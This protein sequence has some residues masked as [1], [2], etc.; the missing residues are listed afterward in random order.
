MEYIFKLDPD[1]IERL[2]AWKEKIKKKHKEYGTFTYSFTP[3]G[4]GTGVA[5]H[6]HLTRKSIDLSDV[7]KW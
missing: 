5:V 1:Q 7:D 6:S 2:E 3:Y 4:M